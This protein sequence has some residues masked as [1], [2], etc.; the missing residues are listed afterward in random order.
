MPNETVTFVTSTFTFKEI[1][2]GGTC[3]GNECWSESK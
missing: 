1:D 2:Y 3:T